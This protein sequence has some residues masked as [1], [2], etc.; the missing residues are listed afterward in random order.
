VLDFSL[1]LFGKL[2]PI[3]KIVQTELNSASTDSAISAKTFEKSIHSR[4]N[5]TA[6]RRGK[7]ET[8]ETKTSDG[9]RVVCKNP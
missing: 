9:N 3:R 6:F 4:D 8:S 7:K 2:N 5:A 1:E